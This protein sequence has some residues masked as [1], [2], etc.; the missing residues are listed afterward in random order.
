MRELRDEVP[1]EPAYRERAVAAAA[2]LG[3]ELPTYMPG[4][5]RFDEC[6]RCGYDSLRVEA[7]FAVTSEGVQPTDPNYGCDRCDAE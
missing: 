6:P 3:F 4:I 7:V 2:E 1:E 5:V